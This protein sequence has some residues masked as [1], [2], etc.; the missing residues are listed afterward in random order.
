VERA[1]Q[2]R[3]AD[4]QTADAD[5]VEQLAAQ[6]SEITSRLEQIQQSLDPGSAGAKLR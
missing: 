5:A 3:I 4:S 6:L 2:E 1:R